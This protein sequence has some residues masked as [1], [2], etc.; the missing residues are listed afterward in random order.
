MPDRVTFDF[1]TGEII[2][3]TDTQQGVEVDPHLKDKKLDILQA[4]GY[5]QV[6]ISDL[7]HSVNNLLRDIKKDNVTG[8]TDYIDIERS[9]D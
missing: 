1:E 9:K 8:S 2:F 7:L 5:E 6:A 3:Y 4:A